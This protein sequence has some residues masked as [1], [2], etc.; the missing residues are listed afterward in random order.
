MSGAGLEEGWAGG[1]SEERG[2]YRADGVRAFV[3]APG[4]QEKYLGEAAGSQGESGGEAV[5]EILKVDVAAGERDLAL[6]GH[7]AEAQRPPDGV[8][9][10]FAEQ[11]NIGRAEAV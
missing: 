11:Q 10:V 5:F 3:A 6:V 4:E 9:E 7:E 8:F 1:A 2:V